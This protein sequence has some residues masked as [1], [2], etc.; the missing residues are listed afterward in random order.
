MIYTRKIQEAIDFAVKTHEEPIKQKR[1]GKEVP[2]V[3]HSLTVGLILAQASASE[4]VV[5]AG[6]LHDTIEDCE[7]YSSVTKEI[8]AEK[9]GEAVAELVDSVTEKDK[10]LSWHERK[11]L[12]LEEIRQFPHDS[13]LLKSADVIS[14]NTEL[15]Q[16]YEREGDKT[17]ERFNAPKEE[18]VEHT[19]KVIGVILTAWNDSP[20]TSDL[21][22]I[23]RKLLLM[24]EIHF[25]KK[26]PA[27]IISMNEYSE[28]M[29]ISCSVCGWK[30]T[31]KG[32]IETYDVLMD[33]DCPWCDKKVLIV[34]YR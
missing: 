27:K 10:S 18:S 9:F 34:D 12:A 15:I 1:K 6:I 22:S 26:F 33:V 20:L 8:I 28:D 29:K 5:I 11:E 2:Y 14:N 17:F 31:P 19:L 32:N 7:P 30:G 21:V 16:D 13:L 4:E 3:T 24:T 23:A 25:M